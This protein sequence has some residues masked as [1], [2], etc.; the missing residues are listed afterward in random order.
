MRKR[1]RKKAKEK[2]KKRKKTLSLKTRQKV[3][4]FFHLTKR[5]GVSLVTQMVENL[6][7]VRETQLDP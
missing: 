1:N 3:I 7:A 5:K 6:P 2:D 4:F